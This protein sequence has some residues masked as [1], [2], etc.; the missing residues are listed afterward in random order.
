[1]AQKRTEAEEKQRIDDER[2]RNAKGGF[3]HN[4]AV[5]LLSRFPLTKTKYQNW[6]RGRRILVGWLLWLVC[7]P[8]IPAVAIALW[9]FNDPEGFKQ[10]SWAKGLIALFVAW[11]GMF[12]W[13]ATNQA[14]PDIDGIYSPT[15]T[16]QT[17]QKKEQSKA[18][19]HKDDKQKKQ[20][21]TPQK[22]DK[23]PDGETNVVNNSPAAVASDEAKKKVKDLKESQP[24]RG[25]TFENCTEAFEA[26]VFNIRRS[27][28]SYQ[29]KLDRD[30]DGIACER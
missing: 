30:G 29:E 21:T 20:H 27:D 10:S 16:K 11:A 13:I 2:A 24:T 6:T 18:A 8:I 19:S 22:Q 7:L 28:R 14:V 9:Y 17:E 5:W 4:G 3:F 1:M 25:R 15:Q 12:G 23:Q 26:G